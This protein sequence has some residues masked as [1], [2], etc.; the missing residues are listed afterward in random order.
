[1]PSLVLR[2][3]TA[4]LVPLDSKIL[5]ALLTLEKVEKQ[6]KNPQQIIHKRLGMGTQ[7]TKTD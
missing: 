1:M 3:F 7:A 2:G 6:T 5:L 4:Q